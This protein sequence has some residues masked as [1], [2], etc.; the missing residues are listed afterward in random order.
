MS[1]KKRKMITTAL[2]VALAVLLLIGGGTFAY[3]QSTS[4]DVKNNF[5]ANQVTVDLTETGNKQ[6][7]IIPGTT[8]KKDPKVT[9]NNTVDAY[10]FVEVTDTTQG[11]V[12]YSIADGWAKL[13]GFDNVYYR[14]VAKDA[15]PNEF[16]VL[17]GDK[18]S[19]S[20]ALENSDMLD[21]DGKLKSGIELTF[22]A[23]AIQKEG[24]KDAVAAYKQIPTEAKTTDEVTEAIANGKA[25]KLADDTSDL[26][27]PIETLTDK[28][29]SIDLNNKKLTV[30]GTNP[31][32]S[33]G[34]SLTLVNG[35]VEWQVQNTAVIGMET[36]SEVTLKNIQSNLGTNCIVVMPGT[37]AA[38]LNI[39]DSELTTAENILVS[40]NAGNTQTGESIQI[41][42]KGSKLTVTDNAGDNAGVLLNVPGTLNIENSTIT[43]DRQAVIVRCGTANIKDSEL[44]CTAKSNSLWATYDAKDWGS[45][46]EVPVAAL[47][48]GN[49]SGKKVYPY[50]ATCTLSNTN[51][52]LN[53]DRL[54]VYVA[55]YNGHTTTISGVAK[56]KITQS[57]D[58]NSNIVIK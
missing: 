27:V 19:Y 43:A 18:V 31:R 16:S 7:D 20:T 38:K 9:V 46:N 17:A 58:A 22:K 55:A 24:F 3:L 11:L 56:D 47:V 2:A 29:V 14:E 54:P 8:Q 40:T 48:A 34:E 15:N 50:D 1:T 39:I 49:R 57:K 13:E 37:N 6:Y 26:T 28:D 35:T 12:E 32:I 45:G 4:K 53:G 5:N 51:V 21:A 10:V 23:H 25:V 44:V 52:T 30:T 41:N 36:G 33:R 42:I